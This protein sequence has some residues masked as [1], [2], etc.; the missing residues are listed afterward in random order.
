MECWNCGGE[1]EEFIACELR[2][3][4]CGMIRDCSDP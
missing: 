1:M 4:S 2:C 3:S